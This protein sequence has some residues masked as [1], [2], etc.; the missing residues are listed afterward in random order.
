MSNVKCQMSNVK[1]PND[2]VDFKIIVFSSLVLHKLMYSDYKS[3]TTVKVLAGIAP[4]GGFKFI[5]SVFSCSISDKDITVKSGL[6]N[7]QIWEPG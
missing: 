4:G 5:S 1:F 2:C 6:L 7:R 3:H